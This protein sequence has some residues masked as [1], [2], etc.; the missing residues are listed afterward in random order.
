V[1]RPSARKAPPRD[2]LSAAAHAKKV[3][4]GN[5]IFP[6]PV[7]NWS[8]GGTLLIPCTNKSETPAKILRSV[9]PAL[10]GTDSPDSPPK[11]TFFSIH[12]LQQQFYFEMKEWHNSNL[13]TTD[14]HSGLRPRGATF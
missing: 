13:K 3:G 8:D 1:K 14:T 12:F 7:M 9:S 6:A 11:S 2:S 10:A 5:P 4:T